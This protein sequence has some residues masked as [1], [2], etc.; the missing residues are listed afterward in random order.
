MRGHSESSLKCS[1]VSAL[2]N[3]VQ[4][5]AAAS[6][7]LRRSAGKGEAQAGSSLDLATCALLSAGH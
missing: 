3:T 4:E 7:P 1:G 2:S 6:P 5:Q